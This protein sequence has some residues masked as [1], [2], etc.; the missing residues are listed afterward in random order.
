MWKS[1]DGA[2]AE[3]VETRP[4][5]TRNIPRLYH[6]DARRGISPVVM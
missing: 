4:G 3:A 2:A 6:Q 1:Y 5:R